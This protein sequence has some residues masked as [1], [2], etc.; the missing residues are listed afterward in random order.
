MAADMKKKLLIIEDDPNLRDVYKVLFE[1]EG[2]EVQSSIDGISVLNNYFT[3]PDVILLDRWLG[4]VDGLAVCRHLKASEATRDVPVI[5]VSAS[6]SV[7]RAAKEAGADAA[8]DKPVE[9]KKLTEIVQYWATINRN[10][11]LPDSS[12]E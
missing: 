10:K 5:L 2:Y 12:D 11:P 6:E 3:I 8:L 7:R 9:R 1:K 4:L